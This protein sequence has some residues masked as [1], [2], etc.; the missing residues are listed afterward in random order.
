MTD[1]DAAR[2]EAVLDGLLGFTVKPAGW[3]YEAIAV[4]GG[5]RV[6]LTAFDEESARVLMRQRIALAVE[7]D[8]L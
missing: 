3:L 6:S 1:L 5:R 4:I 2:A 7:E 8:C